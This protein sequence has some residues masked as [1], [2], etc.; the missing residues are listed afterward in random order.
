MA[1]AKN[2]EGLAAPTEKEKLES[3]K[4]ELK[5]QQREQ[6][7]EAKR[8]AREIARQED[9]LGEDEESNGLLTLGA[10]LLIVALWLAVIC[11]VIKLDVGGFGSR[12]LALI[13][14]DVPVLNKIL[15]ENSVT[16]TTDTESYGGYTSLEEAVEQIRSLEI[17]LEQAQ[18][19]SRS[20]DEELDSLKAEVLRLQE[21]ENSQVEFQRV[22][23]EFYEEVVYAENGPGAEA[24]QKY[25]ESMDPT[26]AEYIYKQVVTQLEESQEV[27]D[28]AEAYSQMKPKQAAGIF[29]SM[30]DDLDLAARIL[31]VMSA[32]DRGAI[33]G[34]MDPEVAARLTKIMDPES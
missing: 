9:A 25:Y 12:V 10:T 11:V 3:E 2:L 21:F 7:K 28:Y 5:R 33:M 17:Q 26:T 8:R 23:T 27:Q 1:K 19:E 20:K 22:K 15:P 31:K 30:T 13:L 18:N 4:K 14:Q 34:Q 6:R 32:E 29:E 16:E 24:Y